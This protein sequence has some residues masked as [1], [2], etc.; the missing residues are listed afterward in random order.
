VNLSLLNTPWYIKQLRDLDPQL[1]IVWTDGQIESIYIAL[2]YVIASATAQGRQVRIPTEVSQHWDNESL[3]YIL[4]SLRAIG[5]DPGRDV[6][7]REVA[8][9]QIIRENEWKK[10]IYIATSVPDVMG[11]GSQLKFEGLV[12]RAYPQPVKETTDIPRLRKNLYEVFKYEGFV[13]PGNASPIGDHEDRVYKESGPSRMS[14]NNHAAGFS[15]L[16]VEIIRTGGDPDDALKEMNAAE[17][18]APGFIGV[19]IAKGYVLENAERWEEAEAHYRNTA[20]LLPTNWQMRSRRGACLVQ[21]GRFE[22]AVV[23]FEHAITLNP[24]QYEPYNGVLTAYYNLNQPE[25]GVKAIERWLRRHPED[26]RVQG[27]YQQLLQAI[28]SG[29]ASPPA[30]DTTGSGGSN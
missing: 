22:E 27:L 24:D 10:P 8:V 3:Q 13:K 14:M 21:L 23:D 19:A 18:I 30:R 25:E 7:V 20:D 4:E 29:N 26:Q 15:R 5:A 12:Q 2:E 17:Q 9:D 11:L 1:P 6:S 16:G 28:R